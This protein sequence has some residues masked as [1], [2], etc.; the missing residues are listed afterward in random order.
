MMTFR[1]SLQFFTWLAHK[2]RSDLA[3]QNAAVDGRLRLAVLFGV[4]SGLS[5]RSAWYLAWSTYRDHA[6]E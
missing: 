2:G 5:A 3:A 6:A 1:H 4:R